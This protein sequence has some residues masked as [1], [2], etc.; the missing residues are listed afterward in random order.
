M[1]HGRLL[2]ILFI[3]MYFLVF[4]DWLAFVGVLCGGYGALM[5]YNRLEGNGKPTF[6]YRRKNED[7]ED[8]EED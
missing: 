3:A 5:F 7:D 2:M 4:G 6:T 8:E 1:I